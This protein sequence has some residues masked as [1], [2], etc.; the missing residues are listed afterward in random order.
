MADDFIIYVHN[1]PSEDT[2]GKF[3][4]KNS[5]IVEGQS[6]MYFLLY[7]TDDATG[8][9]NIESI[10]S[11]YDSI[12]QAQYEEK[13]YLITEG[14]KVSEIEVRDFPLNTSTTLRVPVDCVK[15][16]MVAVMGKNLFLEQKDYTYFYSQK[17]WELMSDPNYIQSENF[18][19]S[20]GR[21]FDIEQ[22]MENVQ[23][24]IWSRALNKI[25][26]ISP[27]ITSMTTDKSDVG[28]FSIT[29]N[30]VKNLS[31]L[32][33]TGDSNIINYFV[34]NRDREHELDFFYKNFQYNDIVFLRFEKLKLE[35]H[36]KEN[37]DKSTS[38]DFEVNKNLLPGQ[39]WDMIGL[40]DNCSLNDSF[41]NLNYEVTIS[42]RDFM[43]LLIEDGSYF[44]NLALL[45]SQGS[46]QLVYGFNQN[47]KWFKRNVMD[48]RMGGKYSPYWF[49]NKA[50]Q[51]DETLAFIINQLTN[52]GILGGED[53]FS[54]YGDKR[55]KF[56]EIGQDTLEVNP[57]IEQKYVDGVWQII[58]LMYQ[59]ILKDRFV[60]DGALAYVDGTILE[61]FNKICQ[62]PFVEFFGDTYGN[63]FNFV[64]RQPPFTR[65][66]IRSFLFGVN[67]A[68]YANQSLGEEYK[69][70]DIQAK[71]ISG[72][73]SLQYDTT[74]YSWYQLTPNDTLLGAGA[75]LLAGGLIPIQAFTRIAECFG[76][77]RLVVP[78]NYLS[79]NVI[80]GF[81]SKEDRATY[82]GALL[83]DLKFVIDTNMYL[84]FT[85]KGTIT[86]V[87]GD[88]RIKKGM[89]IRITPMNEIFYVDSVSNYI[90]FNNEAIYRSTTL[91]VS[92]GMIEDYIHGANGYE[93]DGILIREKDLPTKFSYFDIAKTIIK[94]SSHI[95][96][97]TDDGQT[98]VNGKEGFIKISKMTEVFRYL[99]KKY[100]P[101]NEDEAMRIMQ[102]ESG[103]NPL[104]NPI[105]FGKG[106]TKGYEGSRDWGL[107]Q[108][109]DK[110]HPEVDFTR[111]LNPEYNIQQASRIF[112]EAGN[113]WS[114]WSA[115][116]VPGV[117]SPNSQKETKTVTVT[118]RVQMGT[119]NI[120]SF[121]KMN[122]GMI[123]GAY[124]EGLPLVDNSIDR[125]ILRF[126]SGESGFEDLMNRIESSK[127]LNR[128]L[129]EFINYVHYPGG[130]SGSITTKKE[131]IAFAKILGV[132]SNS[133]L[134][135]IDSFKIGRE[136]CLFS[137]GSIVTRDEKTQYT[138]KQLQETKQLTTVWEDNYKFELDDKQFDF[139]LKRKQFNI[140]KYGRDQ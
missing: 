88:R 11:S 92:R 79:A 63:E 58:H 87:K 78:D 21:G 93:E 125:S 60:V 71:D 36:V 123:R 7:S 91:H 54:A 65:E 89:F 23:V 20:E 108:I 100:F 18:T 85:R 16:E 116:R 1:N 101:N 13:I 28:S 86:L 139:F 2:I 75:T 25:I 102:Q 77:H 31:E 83:N 9:K 55:A 48:G 129:L 12:Q 45:Q 131:S 49:T 113:S 107:F 19:G 46:Q 135:S 90:A 24:W 53:L 119:L 42:G 14:G 59:D 35:E 81:E 84:P 56:Y 64:V 57:T 103:G 41:Q 128:T 66:A 126:D 117:I 30:P 76:N 51:I 43:K 32:E 133:T 74:Y 115:S 110:A 122:P 137:T 140:Y 15:L 130:L 47:D 97:S 52:L 82:R 70:I 132:S 96:E 37:S 10:F 26:D 69:L 34:L 67:N 68:E 4:Y 8:L 72:Y 94:S 62:A 124:D 73:T 136:L 95:V 112:T 44:M 40:I 127:K 38:Y 121:G 111:V 104:A 80:S 134:S 39:I 106:I 120:D 33:S 22:M 109:N 29:V 17:L 114:Q 61:Q 98:P 118:Y 5:S 6:L 3:F 138:Y 50:R 105:N 99:V 27:F